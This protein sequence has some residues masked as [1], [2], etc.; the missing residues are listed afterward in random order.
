MPNLNHPS[1]HHEGVIKTKVVCTIGPASSSRETLRAFVEEGMNIA[2]LNLSHCTHEFAL[3]VIND[4]RQIQKE[5]NVRSDVAIWIDVNGPKVRTGKLNEPVTLNKGDEFFFVNDLSIIGDNKRIATTYTKELVQVGD[6]MCVDDGAISFVVVE[7]LENSIRCIVENTG[8]LYENKGINFPQRTIED[9]PAL[10]AKDKDD[11][12]FAIA[13]QVDFVSVSCLRDSE[14]IEELRRLFL[15]NSKIKIL[16]KIENKRGMDNYDQILKLADGI[17][18]DRGYL[19]AEVDLE[20]VVVAQ[21][22][23]INQANQQGKPIFIANQIL[24]SMKTNIRPTRSEAA[25]VANAVMDGADGLV[26]SAETAIGDFVLE[27]LILMRK[28]CFKAEQ[29]TNYLEYQ[30]KAMRNVTKPIHINESIASSAVLCARQV[31]ATLILI[32]TEQGGTA[33]LVAKYRPVIPVLA[34][35][36]VLS[37]A[38]QLEAHFGL[39]PF[40]RPSEENVIQEALKYAVEIGLAKSGEIA[41][42]TSG[43]VIGFKEG[44]T[45]KMQVLTIP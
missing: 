16:A 15:G 13:N 5:L 26:L 12:A 27:S 38:R 20:V 1:V 22:K 29:N 6:Q 18:I 40:Y 35:T 43:Q 28:I 37:T 30:M 31:G 24:E 36:T 11:V 23:M 7:R 32:I 44:T 9:L 14:D 42:I 21:K 19:G 33:R 4:L 17:I 10:S 3:Q 2:R 34:A 25:D 45:T 8:V 39:V 41:V